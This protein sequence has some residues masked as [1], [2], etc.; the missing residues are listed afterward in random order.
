MCG[1]CV[2]S[3]TKESPV[4]LTQFAACLAAIKPRGPDVT[5]TEVMTIGEQWRGIPLDDSAT[6]QFIGFT[7]LH[8]QGSALHAP[9][10]SALHASGGA[11]TS[12]SGPEQPFH[13]R[14]GSR[15]VVNGEI[16]NATLLI[17]EHALLV[18]EGASD[19]AVIPALLERG[20]TLREVAR[21]LDGDFA[22]VHLMTDG[23]IEVA[24][25]PYGVRPLFYRG[26]SIAS[27]IKGLLPSNGET[28]VV[29][30]GTIVRF[31]SSLSDPTVERWH[32]V[33]W[34]KNPRLRSFD[35]AGLALQCALDAAVKKRLATVRGLGACL[36]GGL[37][38]S[39]VAAIAAF[40]L[41]EYGSPDCPTALNTYSIGMEGSPDLLAARKVAE[42]IGS[43]HHERIITPDECIA[44][45]PHVIRA[46]ESFDITTVRASVGNWLLGKFI[47][48]V[49]PDVKVVLNGDGSDEILG[50][51]LYMRNAPNAAAFE[52]EIDRLLT[53]IHLYDVARSERCMAAHGLE[54]RSPFLDRQFVSV[55]RSIPTE[56]LVASKARGQEK[57]VLRYAYQGACCGNLPHEILWRPKE[58]FSDGIS[59]PEDSWFKMVKDEAA[60]Y[61]QIFTENFGSTTATTPKYWMPRWTPGATDPSARTLTDLYEQ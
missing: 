42:H 35:E 47:A 27:E 22:I 25:D 61:R 19:C 41:G 53:E 40:N 48:E 14:D 13:L 30:P 5:T 4:D 21:L 8:I 15:L 60:W 1:I 29:P 37:D 51:Y 28:H 26:N 52:N 32:E 7:R 54:S 38:S 39:L 57:R 59:R 36:S 11:L 44:A 33:P 6:Q 23:S 24:R 46:I 45:I 3:S 31:K 2:A 43:C 34:L 18:N 9:N 10:P 50:G 49:T 16:F 55:A 58:A 20:F 12:V 56:L 17:Q